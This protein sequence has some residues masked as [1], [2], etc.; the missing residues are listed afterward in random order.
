MQESWNQGRPCEYLQTLRSHAMGLETWSV[1]VAI[2]ALM[3]P[4]LR[5]NSWPSHW[6]LVKASASRRANPD[7]H[8]L[9]HCRATGVHFI[10]GIG[11]AL[12]GRRS[13]IHGGRVFRHPDAMYNSKSN[14]T[15]TQA[16]TPD[17]NCN[18]HGFSSS[19]HLL[20]R[21]WSCG[22]ARLSHVE[23]PDLSTRLPCGP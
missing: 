21:P 2:S 7:R 1:W 16:I 3:G 4:S 6:E 17:H 13:C 10:R 11:I 12:G 19:S 15:W 22:T 18:L 5:H 8:L 23:I 20:L 9:Y 14:R